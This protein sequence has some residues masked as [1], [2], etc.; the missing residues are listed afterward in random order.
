MKL[1]ERIKSIFPA[2]KQA[3]EEAQPQ[4]VSAV[5]EP[6]TTPRKEVKK[7][8]RFTVISWSVTSVLVVAL[9]SGTLYYK[10]TLPPQ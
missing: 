2:R 1:S 6:S 8:D 4:A 10:S 9:L 7:A 5:N 3:K